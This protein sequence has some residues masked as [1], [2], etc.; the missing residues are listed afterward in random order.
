MGK[1]LGWISQKTYINF[2]TFNAIQIPVHKV[3]AQKPGRKL[4]LLSAS[5]YIKFLKG[6]ISFTTIKFA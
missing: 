3:P 6:I 5:Q 4:K 2:H 1:N